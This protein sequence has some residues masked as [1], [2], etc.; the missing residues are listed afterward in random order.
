MGHMWGGDGL[1]APLDVARFALAYL[2][3][4]IL[5]GYALA[6]LARP[7]LTRLEQ[8]ALAIPCAYTLV[9]LCGLATVALRLPFGPL[10]YA[11]I[12]APITLAALFIQWHG[13]AAGRSARGAA[14]YWWLAP[15]GVAAAQVAA[16]ALVYAGDTV[17]VGFDVV[18]HVAWTGAIARTQLFPLALLSAHAG[19]ANGGFYPP[20]FHALGALTLGIAPMPTYRA[21]FYGI[22]AAAAFLPLALF[23]YV[24]A[25]FD[26]PDV[27]L[28]GRRLAGLAVLTTLAF[29]A[30]PLATQQIG[31]YP[32]LASLLF[33]PA[34][35]VALRDG[36]IGGDRRAATLAALLGV[37]L[38]YT[39]P[40]EFVTVALIAPALLGGRRALTPL[41]PPVAGEGEPRRPWPGPKG[42]WHGPDLKRSTF[43][44]GHPGLSMGARHFFARRAATTRIHWDRRRPSGARLRH[45][46]WPEATR[47]PVTAGRPGSAAS[48]G[49]PSRYPTRT[50]GAPPPSGSVPC[51]GPSGPGF[52]HNRVARMAVTGA[53]I[54]AA[55][56]I[57]ALPAL[58]AVRHTMVSGAQAE[59]RTRHDFA[60]PSRPQL[61]PVLGTY[62]QWLYGHNLAYLLLAATALGIA[63]LLWRR[64]LRGLVVVCAIALAVFVDSNS[65]NLLRPLYVLSF[66]WALL[67]RLVP[68][69]YWIIPPLAAI[70]LDRVARV[71]GRPLRRR[72]VPFAALCA[73]PVVLFGL[74]VPYAVS[75][76]RAAAYA[77]ALHTV[78]PADLAA[79]AWLARHAPPNSVALNDGDL[80]PARVILYDAP[81]DAGRWLP[82]LG[83]PRPLFG[84]NGDG[85]GAAA[86]QLYL[87]AHAADNPLP[88]RAASFV[89]RYHVHYVYYGAAVRPDAIRHLSLPRLLADPALRL[90]YTSA[91]A[92]RDDGRRSSAA[93]RQPGAYVFA[94]KS[95]AVAVAERVQAPHA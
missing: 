7:R 89:D 1:F 79:A 19:D 10:A 28:D 58:V 53:A 47:S 87:L 17:P 72:G 16:C 85:P 5:P 90:V 88:A 2:V 67:Q 61:G 66:P 55:W 42:P 62:V 75:T 3:L 94:F 18:A 64:R 78:A 45:P 35:A 70:G 37:G 30:V 24:R 26:Q 60:A 8:L 76:A 68:T 59:I 13:R 73:V 50:H 38:F 54:A 49:G 34:I 46:Q 43:D 95:V 21:V 52:M 23:S 12:A 51:H 20:A 33:V 44:R 56:L 82:L 4:A 40:T 65:Y 93:C 22:V 63:W 91:L 32:F 80:E 74:A 83:A 41:P 6:T 39:H 69:H 11:A 9:V 77:R 25:V 57:G 31:L 92:C 48:G 27:G 29:D 14:N 71:V 86:E 15:A 36:V 84:H 81:I